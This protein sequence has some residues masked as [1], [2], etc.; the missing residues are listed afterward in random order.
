[1][2]QLVSKTLNNR[3]PRAH[4]HRPQHGHQDGSGCFLCL[5]LVSTILRGKL[6]NQKARA[7]S[8]NGLGSQLFG[9]GVLGMGPNGNSEEGYGVSN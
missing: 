2:N 5:P 7:S 8:S 4:H 6:T 1:M 9:R 3:V